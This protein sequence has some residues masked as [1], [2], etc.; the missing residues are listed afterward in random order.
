VA[1]GGLLVLTNSAYR[2]KYHNTPLDPNEDWSDANALAT[3]F[4]VSY[5]EG[6]ISAALAKPDGEHP[7]M[8]GVSDLELIEGNGLPF[9]LVEGQVLAQAGGEPVV[10]L[11]DY[12]DAGGQVLALADLGILGNR[13][14]AH[15]LTFWGNL[16]QYARSR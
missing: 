6:A 4:G 8:A 14:E 3:Q 1:G 12:G 2:L 10:A 5:Q 9:T 15:N 7:L 13:G 11:L 16:A